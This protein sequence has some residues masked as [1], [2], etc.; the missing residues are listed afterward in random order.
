MTG[1]VAFFFKQWGGACPKSGGRELDGRVWNEHSKQRIS[2]ATREVI[3]S[4]TR[5]KRVFVNLFGNKFRLV[6]STTGY[7]L[8]PLS[9][10][11]KSGKDHHVTAILT[12]DEIASV[13]TKVDGIKVA[14]I[15]G[16]L[17]MKMLQTPSFDENTA[18]RIHVSQLP[19]LD[20][21]YEMLG[22]DLARARILAPVLLVAAY[23]S[24]LLRWR[25]TKNE[26]YLRIKLDHR[27][28]C[29]L[30]VFSRLAGFLVALSPRTLF[31]SMLKKL[32]F[33]KPSKFIQCR[34]VVALL[35]RNDFRGVYWM[36]RQGNTIFLNLRQKERDGTRMEQ[37]LQEVRLP[38]MDSL[39]LRAFEAE[40]AV[41][42]E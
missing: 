30:K 12:G 1:S 14:D 15:P 27:V 33:T 38:S 26:F 3:G 34:N 9:R 20:G 23:V 17:F 4:V 10:H 18:A 29:F 41:I 28:V 16:E 40:L 35:V 7:V 39:P 42:E 25:R 6:K 36:W 22:M 19:S 24:G 2:M 11:L 31:P 21:E 13:H 5:L 32:L 8:S 37:L